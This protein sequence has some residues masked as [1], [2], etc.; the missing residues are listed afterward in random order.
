MPCAGRRAAVST[1]SGVVL[2]KLFRW[3]RILA[4]GLG[5]AVLGLG[6]LL[7]SVTLFPAIAL[8]TPDPARR[9]RR[10]QAVISGS[11]RLY[12]WLLRALGVI[13]LAIDGREQIAACRGVLVVANHPTLLDVVLLMSVVPNA[14]CVVKHQLWRNRFLGPVVRAAGYIR[15]D[16]DADTF[17]D[18]CRAALASGGNLII[19]P[20]GTRSVPGQPLRFQ[21]GFANIALLAPAD[22][23]LV[24]ISCEPITLVKGSP[25]YAVPERRAA[26]R[27]AAEAR[28]SA[29]PVLGLGERSLGARRLAAHL[30]S[31]FSLEAS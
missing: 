1:W 19:F 22:M 14:Q 25:W 27:V 20:E 5:F 26:F 31:H 8:A 10:V 30:Q 4:T 17:I 3:W 2:A 7:L 6:G 18:R 15:N 11:F 29:A 28:L 9:A 16:V 12:L 21:R 23:Q 13:R 24:R